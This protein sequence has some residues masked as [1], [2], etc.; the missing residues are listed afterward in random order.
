MRRP[1][2]MVMAI[3]LSIL[4]ASEPFLFAGPADKEIKALQGTWV[5]QAMEVDGA[6]I[7]APEA[8]NIVEFSLT[9]NQYASRVGQTEIEAGTVAIDSNKS[10]ATIDLMP[11]AG[12]KKGQVLSGIY[13]LRGDRLVICVA[14]PPTARPVEFSALEG[15]GRIVIIYKRGQSK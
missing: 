8:G 1:F 15:D 3:S 12:E 5:M 7:E 11:F 9:G 6:K 4:A 14:T 2:P 13:L 10:P